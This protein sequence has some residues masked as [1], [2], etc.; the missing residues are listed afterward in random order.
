MN[1]SLDDSSPELVYSSDWGIQP[2]ADP[3]F[4]QGTYHVAEADGATVNFT[5]SG[6]AVVLYGSKGPGH[7]NYSVQYDNFVMVNISA[8]ASEME[9]QQLLFQNAFAQDAEHF[10]SFAA[11]LSA[12]GP[13]V[14]FDYLEITQAES[15]ANGS[16]PMPTSSGAVATLVPPWMASQSTSS[17]QSPTPSLSPSPTTHASP[18]NV[19]LI[20][21]VLFGALFGLLLLALA[22][23]FLLRRRGRFRT[24][25]PRQF[26]YSVPLAMPKGSGH[27]AHAPVLATGSLANL[28]GASPPPGAVVSS[29]GAGGGAGYV[30]MLL[31]MSSPTHEGSFASELEEKIVREK[32]VQKEEE[33]RGTSPASGS[34][35]GSGV[36]HTTYTRGFLAS[37][38][39]KK[40]H[41]GDA[42]SLRTDF[43]QV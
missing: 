11:H 19:A 10:I 41:K 2:A 14:D 8:Y 9:Y 35:S 20:L 32:E 29:V 27:I 3:A 40:A 5:F 4:F 23:Y 22:A 24:P 7:G 21:A 34:G 18:T 33:E 38:P 6:S 13:W 42:D 36:G 37:S 30:H 26:R 17:S 39:F 12:E 16:T 28:Y 15:S 1:F 31:P 43:L 25:R